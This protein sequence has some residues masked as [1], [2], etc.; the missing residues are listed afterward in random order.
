MT[1]TSNLDRDWNFRIFEKRLVIIKT[2]NDNA[3]KVAVLDVLTNLM[4]AVEVPEAISIQELG[5]EKEYLVNLKVYTETLARKIVFDS[6]KKAV[7][8]EV[9]SL[10]LPYTIHASKEVI[11]SAGA[12]QSPQLLMVSGVGPRETLENL[13]IEVVSELPGVGQNMWDHILFG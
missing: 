12:F 10:G 6:N 13:D 8:V 3:R 9:Q 5:V 1:A 11:V 7:G 2:K 4:F